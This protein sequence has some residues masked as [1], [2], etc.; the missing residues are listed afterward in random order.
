MLDPRYGRAWFNKGNALD[1][2]CRREEA[3]S[4]Y[5]QAL[6]IDPRLAQAWYNKAL[7]EEAC[8][9]HATMIVT[10]RQYLNVAR[11]IPSQRDY[12]A[13]AERRLRELESS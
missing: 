6:A 13:E 2:L 10:W 3:I 4:C 12:V 8:G 1:A 7:A 9:H 5:D 11:E